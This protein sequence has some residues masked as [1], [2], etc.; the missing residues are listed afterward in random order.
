MATKAE[1]TKKD[2]EK[3][4]QAITDSITEELC[5]KGGGKVTLIGFG[6]FDVADRAA[7]EG[8]NPQTGK[9][10]NI[11]A[12]RAVRFRVGKTLKDAVNAK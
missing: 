10:M 3:A 11:P 1:M 7:R 4:L 9:A 8:R 2:A 12:S 6:S 5:R